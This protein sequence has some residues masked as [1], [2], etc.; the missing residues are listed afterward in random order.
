MKILIQGATPDE[1]D[2][3]LEN[4]TPLTK[5][6]I[7]GY[8]FFTTEFNNNLII[9]SSTQKGIINA[10]IATTIALLTF[11]PDV[12]INQGC[13]GAHVKSLNIGD[14]II[15]KQSKYIN[16]FKTPIKAE[17]CGSNSLEWT[18]HTKRSYATKSTEKLVDIAKKVKTDSTLFVGTLASGDMFSR[19]VDRI[20][21]LQNYFNHLSEDMESAA[22]LKVCEQFTTKRIAF[23]IISNNELLE[24]PFDSTT[25]ATMQHFVI[26]FINLLT[27]N[28]L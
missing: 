14:I 22:V 25:R 2:V 13:A 4:Y 12:V 28:N 27:N 1:I 16:D 8:E 11:S 9:I 18:P 3:L 21:F 24:T 6:Q 7:A 20:N 17:G 26:D 15:G 23:R 19:E 5:T 10:T